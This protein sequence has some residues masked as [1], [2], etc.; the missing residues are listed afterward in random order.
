[1][2]RNLLS[3]LAIVIAIVAFSFTQPTKSNLVAKYWFEVS[4]GVTVPFAEANASN[5]LSESDPHGC[6]QAGSLVCTRS[7]LPTQ[8]ETF[9]DGGVQKRRPISGQTPVDILNKSVE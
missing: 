3:L 9:M 1:M 5:Y 2:K 7:F 6:P 8:T 4:S